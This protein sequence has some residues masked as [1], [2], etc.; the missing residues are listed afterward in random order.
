MTVFFYL[1]GF[2]FNIFR[3]AGNSWGQPLM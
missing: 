3:V 1:V 2:Y